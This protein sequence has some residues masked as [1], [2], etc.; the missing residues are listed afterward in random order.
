MSDIEDRPQQ[1]A[2]RWGDRVIDRLFV[3]RSQQGWKHW[4]ASA[5]VGAVVGGGAVFLVEL[6]FGDETIDTAIDAVGG[7]GPFLALILVIFLLFVG[8]FVL[9]MGSSRRATQRA[10]E[11]DDAEPAPAMMASFR[12][13]ALSLA[14]QAGLILLVIFN[15]LPA[16]PALAVAALLLVAEQW[17][18]WRTYVHMDELWRQ[19][20][21]ESCALQ[22]GLVSLLFGGWAVLN[23]YAIAPALSPLAAMVTLLL[24]SLVTSIFASHRRGMFA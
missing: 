21:L 7:I 14:C 6:L 8:L 2:G 10:M 18:G 13:S 12:L 24:A 15:G 16:A 23:A 11:L 19:A 3:P 4:L 22:S 1:S 20:T 5:A 9:V 17:L